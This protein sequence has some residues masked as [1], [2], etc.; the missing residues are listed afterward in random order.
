M[1]LLLLGSAVGCGGVQ[2]S[3][4]GLWLTWIESAQR[5][6]KNPAKPPGTGTMLMW[7]QPVLSGTS[8]AV[9]VRPASALTWTALVS[10]SPTHLPRAGVDAAE[11]RQQPATVRGDD[12]GVADED[13]VARAGLDQRVRR[14]PGC[15]RHRWRRGSGRGRCPGCPPSCAVW[16][17][18]RSPEGVGKRMGFCSERVASSESFTGAD[19]AVG[20]GLEAGEGRRRCPG[21][22]PGCRRTR[23][24]QG[25]RRGGA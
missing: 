3:P 25:C 23:R 16:R 8:C 24:S 11:H 20:A 22:L 1:E 12:R 17:S 2:A 6:R 15:G 5:L 4:S 13:A 18:Q 19:P 10:R 21:C 7:T 14:A 9:Q